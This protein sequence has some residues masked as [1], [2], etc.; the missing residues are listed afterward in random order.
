M[1]QTITNNSISSLYTID[2]NQ[3]QKV[4][5]NGLPLELVKYHAQIENTLTQEEYKRLRT[6]TEQERELIN[7]ALWRGVKHG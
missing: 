1:K 7:N 4:S 6:I 2:E 3:Q 5:P